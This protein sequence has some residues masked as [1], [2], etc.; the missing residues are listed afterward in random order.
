MKSVAVPVLVSLVAFA[1]CDRA[2]EADQQAA[3]AGMWPRPFDVPPTAVLHAGEDGG[4]WS[5]CR[6]VASE[7]SCDIYHVRGGLDFRQSYRVCI[8]DEPG[9]L[10]GG[11]MGGEERGFAVG[12]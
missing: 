10:A 7:L 2:T 5:D 8:D 6:F 9:S 12:R 3:I 4:H 11:V 1:A